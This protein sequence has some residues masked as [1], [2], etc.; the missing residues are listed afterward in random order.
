MAEDQDAAVISLIV[1]TLGRTA[2]LERL[3]DSLEQQGFRRFEVIV[4]DQNDDDRLSALVAPGRWRF[5]ARRIHR[6]GE[7]GASRAR[8]VGAAASTAPILLFPDDD[9]WY[10]ADFLERGLAL[11]ER[12]GADIVTGRSVD[13]AGRSINGR[14]APLAAAITARS[15]WNMQQEWITFFRREIFERAGG[16]DE[17][18]GVGAA[19]PWRCA[20]GPDII[21][22]ALK[23]GATCRYE[24]SLTAFHDDLLAGAPDDA[25][26]AKAR[27]Y[28]RGKGRV[29][30]MHGASLAEKC[31]WLARPLGGVILSALRG[32]GAFTRYYAA[33]LQGR[34]E[35]MRG[36]I[37][38]QRPETTR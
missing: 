33:M 34:R 23:S 9:C 2:Q 1:P 16:Y 22:R 30:A 24:P 5:P 35:G 6:P 38:G 15:V 11:M 31:Y 3:F 19:T 21:L 18:L 17:A 26:I 36:R 37:A 20:E 12:H 27:D 8:N 25:M 13:P 28:G 29:L 32:R 7:R 14:F 10:P 4:V